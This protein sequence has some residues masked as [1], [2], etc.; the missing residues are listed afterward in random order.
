MVDS[1]SGSSYSHGNGYSS[2]SDG[3]SSYDYG[4]GYRT[5]SN[6]G[7]PYFRQKTKKH[8]SAASIKTPKILSPDTRK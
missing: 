4:N 3:N 8:L 1:S 7:S 2:Y 5:Y 6:G